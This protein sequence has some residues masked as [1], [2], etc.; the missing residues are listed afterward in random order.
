MEYPSSEPCRGVLV[1]FFPL[2]EER[3]GCVRVVHELGVQLAERDLA[4]LCFDYAGCGE[5]PGSFTSLTWDRLLESGHAALQVAERR[6]PGLPCLGLGIR[7]GARILLETAASTPPLLH[8]M[9]F[10]EPVLDGRRW[11]RDAVRR[12]RFRQ[13]GGEEESGNQRLDLDG[14]DFCPELL[15]ALRERTGSCEPPG[16]ALSC[17]QV[18]HRELPSPVLLRMAQDLQ[19]TADAVRVQPFWLESGVVDAAPLLEKTVSTL[20][21]FIT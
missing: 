4:L 20:K 5:S 7:T 1:A 15:E 9:V 18:G 3:K 6:W 2:A 14:Y 11:L 13:T 12:S 17:L 8:G 19:G 10:W 16:V 21:G